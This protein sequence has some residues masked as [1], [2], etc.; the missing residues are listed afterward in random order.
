VEVASAVP[1]GTPLMLK[2]DANTTYFIPVAA[3][4]TAPAGNLLK[5]GTGA[6]VSPES[7]K[8]KYALSVEAG[9]AHFKKIEAARAIPVGKAYLVFDE[10]I[11]AR[12]LGFDGFDGGDATGINMV[13]GEGLKVNGSEVY[14]DLQGRRVL[15]PKKGLY[16]VNGK[17]VVIK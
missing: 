17:K 7:G 2:G 14:Y 15:Y 12:E 8:T 10:V 11:A 4:G 9:A 6:N 1:A 16:I 5:A 3:S 13:N